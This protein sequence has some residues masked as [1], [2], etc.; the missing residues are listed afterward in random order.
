MSAKKARGS[1][2][3]WFATVDGNELPC[4]H[5]HWLKWPHYHD[6]FKPVEN[7]PSLTKIQEYVQAIEQEKLVILTDDTVHRDQE[8]AVSGFTRENYVAIFAVEDVRFDPETGLK[9]TI[10]HRLSDLQ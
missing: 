8:G 2:G 3:S 4:V 1:R 7:G 5:K 6:P 9:F 10:T